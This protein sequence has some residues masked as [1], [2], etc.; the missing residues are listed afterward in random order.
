MFDWREE[1][2]PSPL[3]THKNCNGFD[4]LNLKSRTRRIIPPAL[5]SLMAKLEGTVP[6][7]FD[8]PESEGDDETHRWGTWEELLLAFAVNRYG[9]DRWDS[10][11]SELQKRSS[12]PTPTLLTPQNCKQKYLDLKRRYLTQNDTV[13]NKL[14]NDD[15]VDGDNS[16]GSVPLLEELRKLRVAELRREV[17]RYDLNI[18][19]YFTIDYIYCLFNE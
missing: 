6:N 12:E 17:Q 19:Y 16:K 7:N 5:Q 15:N 13:N 3:I 18:E 1:H 11:A 8:K 9:T 2:N 14:L 10:V 4:Q